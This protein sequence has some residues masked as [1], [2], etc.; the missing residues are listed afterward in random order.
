[1][2]ET[3]QGEGPSGLL[4][5]AVGRWKLDPG[6][7]TVELHTKAM[8]GLAKV[9]AGFKAIEG[10]GIVGADGTVS[11]TFV[12]DARSVDTKNSKRD[13]HLRSGDFF[14]VEKYP[15]FTY[16]VTG[17]SLGA[18]GNK[19][20]VTGTFTVHDQTR[21][22]EVLA[23]ATET[24]TGRVTIAAEAELDR[25]QWGLTWAKMGAGLHNHVVVSAQFTRV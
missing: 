3:N 12:I 21:P 14:E 24:G 2:T 15:T 16:S 8:W 11:G 18:G 17:A 5:G 19:I 6:A 20:K 13:K 25:S 23:T 10:D 4:A 1:M 7:T 22:L 9:K